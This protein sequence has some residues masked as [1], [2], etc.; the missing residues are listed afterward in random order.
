VCRGGEGQSEKGELLAQRGGH[1]V[2]RA[3]PRQG[4]AKVND[5]KTARLPHKVVQQERRPGPKRVQSRR[6]RG[7]QIHPQV[8][9]GNVHANGSWK[10]GNWDSLQ[11]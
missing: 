8:Q 5:E 2:S 9:K 10:G 3:N 11:A 7:G 1:I 6:K 4:V